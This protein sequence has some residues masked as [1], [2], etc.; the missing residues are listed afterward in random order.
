MSMDKELTAMA[1]VLSAMENLDPNERSRVITWVAEKLAIEGVSARKQSQPSGKN[2]G[3]IGEAFEHSTDTIATL[4]NAR[5][6]PDLII[7]AAAHLHFATGKAKFTRQELLAEMRTA[8]AHYKETFLNNLSKYLTGLTKVDRLRLVGKDT[9]ALSNKERQDLEANATP[10]DLKNWLHRDLSKAD[11]VLLALGTFDQPARVQDIK[12]RARDAGHTKFSTWNISQVLER[13]RGAAIN[14]K[15][16]WELTDK[17]RERLRALGVSKFS[18]AAIKVAVDLRAILQKVEDT[19][20]RAFVGSGPMPRVR[21]ASFSRS[22]VLVGRDAR[23]KD[24]CGC[25]SSRCI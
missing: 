20:T 11:K 22:D 15:L 2:D 1:S 6:G 19:K 10:N 23:S 12:N 13:T 18:A 8:P 24:A 9:Y 17:G 14:A 5:S 25:L 21:F 7:A 4:T 3:N 16:G